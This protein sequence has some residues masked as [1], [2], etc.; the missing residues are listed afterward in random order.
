ML[1]PVNANRAIIN[2]PE[3]K[4]LVDR[5]FSELDAMPPALRRD[6]HDAWE[7]MAETMT[8]K[9]TTQRRGR[10]LWKPTGL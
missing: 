6:L 2:A 3:T 4:A 7:R 10:V 5:P 1:S 8:R 9:K